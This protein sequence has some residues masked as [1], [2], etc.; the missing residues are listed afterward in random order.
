MSPMRLLTSLAIVPLLLA[1]SAFAQGDA[2]A[3]NSVSVRT[4][5]LV[6]DEKGAYASGVK[7]SDVKVFEGDVE[8]KLTS[9]A[10]LEPG[11]DISIVADNSGSVRP[12]MQT[13]TSIGK[14]LVANLRTND[15]AQVIR[16]VGRE[17]IEVNQPWTN[18][19]SALISGL[20]DMY[21][22]GG[23][24]AVVD[25][26]Y[27]AS[28]DILSRYN[29]AP[30]RRYAIV[31]I[32]DGEDRNSF[33]SQKDLMKLLAGTPIQIFTITLT[34]DLPK[35]STLGANQRTVGSIVKFVN[36]LAAETGGTATSFTK[37]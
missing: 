6:L 9:F 2:K 36:T 37:S 4:N 7:E 14:I 12:Q 19:K 23:Q 32:S 31:L 27:L 33:H 17:H 26:L 24:S 3:P 35:S 21:V 18:Q 15:N 5:L 28:Q 30:N 8:Q 34:R 20:N 1:A 11:V 10:Q 22:E 16:F 13:I 29:K 25:A